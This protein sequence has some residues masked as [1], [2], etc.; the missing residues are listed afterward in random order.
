MNDDRSVRS[1][2]GDRAGRSC[3]RRIAPNWSPRCAASTT[4]SSSATRPSS[5]CC[6][7]LKPDVHCK[8]TDYTVDTVPERAVVAAYG[9]RTAIVGDPKTHATRDLLARIAR[10]ATRVTQRP[11]VHAR[12]LIVRLGALGDI[13]HA[14]PVAA[15]LRRAFPD[16]RIDWLV[17]AKHREILDLVPVDR[18]PARRSTIAATRPAAR[19]SWPR[20]ASCDGRATTSRI[21]LQGLIK[22]AVLAR[23]S[24]APR[25]VGFASALRARAAGAALLHRRA[26]IRAAA[27][28]YAPRET[29]HV[30]EINLGLLTPLGI[31]AGAPEFPIE[32]VD[33]RGRAAMR[34]RDRRPLRAAQPRRGVAEQALAAGAARRASRAR[35]ASGTG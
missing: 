35:C 6:A 31:T 20:S 7:L 33:S 22:S 13:V 28:I 2:E 8:G 10:P 29:R 14:I 23:L 9:G 25:V 15:A 1:A 32:R 30:V 12:F 19:R 24:G 5:G 11:V 4:S 3:R 21:D 26:T 18:S 34:E 16:A 17:S 27:G